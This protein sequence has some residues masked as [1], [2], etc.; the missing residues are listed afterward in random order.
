M[1]PPGFATLFILPA[2]TYFDSVTLEGVH[3]HTIILLFKIYISNQKYKTITKIEIISISEIEQK[4][5][6]YSS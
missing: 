5:F 3:P 2:K 4:K 6:F 1:G